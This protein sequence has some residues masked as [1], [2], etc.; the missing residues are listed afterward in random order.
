MVSLVNQG[1]H[2]VRSLPAN[3]ST[4]MLSAFGDRPEAYHV[5]RKNRY[6]LEDVKGIVSTQKSS[7]C[8][9]L[10][11]ITGKKIIFTGEDACNL[12]SG[13]FDRLRSFILKVA[14][15]DAGIVVL[16]YTRDPVNYV[17]SA[18]QQNVKRNG[19][20]I[21]E[22]SRVHIQ[23][24][25]NRYK[26]L[27]EKCT[28]VF[29]SS[30]VNFRSFERTNSAGSDIVGDFFKNLDVNIGNIVRIKVNEAIASEWVH[31]LSFL[32][33]MN[34]ECNPG[35]L[36]LLTNIGGARGGLLGNEKKQEILQSASEDIR[37]LKQEFGIDYPAVVE[38]EAPAGEDNLFCTEFTDR[39]C[40][41]FGDL[42]PDTQ[43]A[44]E[45][46]LALP[47]IQSLAD[48]RSGIP[49]L[50]DRLRVQSSMAAWKTS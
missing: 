21:E 2:V 18:V 40:D 17:T 10:H 11:D 29:E 14:G 35:D 15:D 48:S 31:F 8:D 30:Q 4:F 39:L 22:A 44:L 24:T 41:L 9:E 49:L 36:H 26:H 46:F 5:N 12:S 16:V 33:S 7:L 6:S 3:H 34:L 47:E 28:E 38:S 37:F 23:G 1:V 42:N 13:G 43:I 50:R 25:H 32:N 27:F 20:T 19:L 45:Q